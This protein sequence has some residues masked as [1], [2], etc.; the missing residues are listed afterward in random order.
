MG[1]KELIEKLKKSINPEGLFT[2]SGDTA[3]KEIP[4]DNSLSRE[5]KVNMAIEIFENS[6]EHKPREATKVYLAF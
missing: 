3:S 5:D 4:E 6:L 2:V 1:K